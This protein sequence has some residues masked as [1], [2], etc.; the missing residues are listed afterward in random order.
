[1]LVKL[2][3]HTT[4][5]EKTCALAARLCYSG[6]SIE[7]LS[8][9]LTPSVV[10]DLLSRIISS[11]HLSVLEHASFTFAVE[12]VSRALLAQLTR[13]RIASFSVQSQRYVK[14]KG[15]LEFI[16]PPEI[17]KH[18][19]LF[20]EYC[21]ALDY[22]K[23]LYDKMLSRGILAE[24]ARYILPQS[25]STKIILTMN[26]RELRHFFSLRCCN[27]AQWEIRGLACRMLSLAKKAAPLL[28][29]GA[30]PDCVSD[31]CREEKPCGTP[32]KKS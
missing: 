13:H 11:G 25:A 20:S 30:G 7:E 5:P 15:S 3:K 14:F 4:D 6:V 32:W 21:N 22:S 2:L 1:M 8:E 31:S 10:K 27:R 17:K 29:A 12:G 24:D 16:V 9:K 26:T 18:G 28:F 23:K 19:D